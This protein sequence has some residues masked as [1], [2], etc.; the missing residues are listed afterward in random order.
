MHTS[1]LEGFLSLLAPARCPGCD[2]PLP[3]PDASLEAVLGAHGFCPACGP[4]LEPPPAWMAPPA[5]AAAAGMFQGPLADA[6]RRFKYAGA[7]WAAAPLGRLLAHAARPYAGEV[8]AVVPLALHP[9]KLRT[10]GYNPAALLARPVA[11]ALSVPM[12]AAWLKRVRA[13]HSQAGLAREARLANVR[14]AF[15]APPV[16]ARK[17]L[18]IDDVRTTGATLTEAAATL[19]A[20]GHQVRTLALAWAQG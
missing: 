5:A 7:G 17:L 10:R 20:R 9:S 19:A 16:P 13:T 8:E 18:L 1:I 14:G 2:L 12:R 15:G 6:I 11:A 4:L 3:A